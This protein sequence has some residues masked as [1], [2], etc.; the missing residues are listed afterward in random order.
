MMAQV[1][2]K[3]SN[4][5]RTNQSTT[6]NYA[7]EASVVNDNSKVLKLAK[8]NE[9]LK[10]ELRKSN[11]AKELLKEEA[12][13]GLEAKALLNKI[14]E[15]L[16]N[17]KKVKDKAQRSLN[18]GILITVLGMFIIVVMMFIS[19]AKSDFNTLV[20]R[21]FLYIALGLELIGIIKIYISLV[22]K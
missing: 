20:G 9:L 15:K 2:K 12:K 13:K 22:K 6:K 4:R 16:N 17:E 8:E 19:E 11:E 7:K 1:E 10:T 14:S 18:N 21:V 5:T 3:S